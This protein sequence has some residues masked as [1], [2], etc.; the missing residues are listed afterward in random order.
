M[1]AGGMRGFGRGRLGDA[2]MIVVIRKKTPWNMEAIKKKYTE[3]THEGKTY[4]TGM[5]QPASYFPDEKTRVMGTEED[6]KEAITRG[7]DKGP[8]EKFSFLRGGHQIVIAV[9]P[10]NTADLTR[11]LPGDFTRRGGKPYQQK[12]A[13]GMTK[14]QGGSVGDRSGR[15]N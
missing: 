2:K 10:E 12:M 7:P 15:R 13:E 5:L 6:L 9:R 1:P 4:Y 3:Q 8:G 11:N 14:I